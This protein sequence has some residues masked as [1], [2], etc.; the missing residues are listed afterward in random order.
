MAAAD[1]GVVVLV[2]LAIEA[3][4]LRL[5]G[6]PRVVLTDPGKFLTD[7]RVRKAWT[8][9]YAGLVLSTAGLMLWVERTI[10][11][12]LAR[13]NYARAYAPSVFQGLVFGLVAVIA[14]GLMLPARSD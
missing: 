4:L 1:V 8:I 7:D 10:L 3:R 6:I 13:G 9:L 14:V 5:R 12:T 2:A 11:L